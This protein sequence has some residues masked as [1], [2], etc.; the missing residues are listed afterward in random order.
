MISEATRRDVA[1]VVSVAETREVTAKGF[2]GPVRIHRVTAID[3][4]YEV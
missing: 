1:D 3:G 4:S 2:D